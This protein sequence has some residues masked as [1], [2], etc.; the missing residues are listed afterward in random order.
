[1]HRGDRY[2]GMVPM[3]VIPPIGTGVAFNSETSLVYKEVRTTHTLDKG[4]TGQ[5]PKGKRR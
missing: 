5:T 2:L 3:P 4:K 1:M